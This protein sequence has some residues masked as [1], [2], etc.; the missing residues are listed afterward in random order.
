MKSI[1]KSADKRYQTAAEM[2]KAMEQ[3]RIPVMG[4][5]GE[6]ASAAAASSSGDSSFIP[7]PVIFGAI[8]LVLVGVLY[9]VF[10]V[11]MVG[12]SPSTVSISSSPDGAEV[13]INGNVV[14]TTP[15][16]D[17][18]VE[19]GRNL[20]RVT[21][22]DF[23][24]ADTLIQIEEGQAISFAMALQATLP[25]MEEEPIAQSGQTDE[26][27]TPEGT[28]PQ[29]TGSSGSGSSG[30]SSGNQTQSMGRVE[31]SVVPAG[32]VAVGGSESSA[33]LG[34]PFRAELRAG[35]YTVKF[36]HPQHG[37]KTQTIRVPSGKT[38]A[39]TCY[40]EQYVNIQANPVWG[41]IYID[42]A[43][44]GMYTPKDRIPIPVGSH[45]ITVKR[46]GYNTEEG[47]KSVNVRPVFQ[48][49]VHTL[50]FTL[51]KN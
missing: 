24:A 4:T 28:P 49:K 38:I 39:R 41:T 14:G 51:M 42:G 25:G 21:K 10:G 33:S 50:I 48:E 27:P 43:N 34:S 23:Q 8:G 11:L 31:F 20:V 15:L 18:E 46:D 37:T 16:S 29:N 19:T 30:Q 2:W 45:S 40:F 32:T 6:M 36:T 5:A 7:K 22:D 13:E 3:V 44:T 1:D 35:E 17:V 26:Q 12:E 47:V 9:L